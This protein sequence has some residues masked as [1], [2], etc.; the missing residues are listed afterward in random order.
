MFL[1][2]ALH[3]DLLD[4]PGNLRVTFSEQVPLRWHQADESCAS[5]SVTMQWLAADFGGTEN[6]IDWL[7]LGGC[8]IIWVC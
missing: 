3:V 4:L 1:A 7:R 6:E 2:Q 8:K 5:L